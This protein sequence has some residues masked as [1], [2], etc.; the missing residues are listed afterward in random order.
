MAAGLIDDREA[1]EKTTASCEGERCSV[2]LPC[3]AGR[4]IDV[5]NCRALGRCLVQGLAASEL[6]E[7]AP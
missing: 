4:C 6:P 7:P 5:A 1:H 3:A 2:P